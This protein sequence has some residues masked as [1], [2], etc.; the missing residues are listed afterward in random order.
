[1]GPGKGEQWLACGEYVSCAA[2]ARHPAGFGVARHGRVDLFG[3]LHHGAGAHRAREWPGP[4]GDVA[5]EC[6]LCRTWRGRVARY[7]GHVPSTRA[8]LVAQGAGPDL[9]KRRTCEEQCLGLAAVWPSRGKPRPTGAS[10]H[11]AH[12]IVGDEAGVRCVMKPARRG[13]NGAEMWAKNSVYHVDIRGFECFAAHLAHL[14]SWPAQDPQFACHP[15]P[16]RCFCQGQS[17]DGEMEHD[18]EGEP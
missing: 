14:P 12:R 18:M 10:P 6:E 3:K 7:R 17:A 5:A 2:V 15:H 8:A 11:P 1:M 13:Q 4:G 16:G 9:P